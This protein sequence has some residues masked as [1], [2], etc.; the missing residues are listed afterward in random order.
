MIDICAVF[1]VDKVLSLALS[2]LGFVF[3]NWD[4]VFI[5]LLLLCRWRNGGPSAS[6]GCIAMKQP[7][8]DSDPVSF[9]RSVRLS[10][11]LGLLPYDSWFDQ[12]PGFK[13]ISS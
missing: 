2:S 1:T 3:V 10:W 8:Q 12:G 11:S 5:L 13:R 9:D 7:S 6:Q 4:K